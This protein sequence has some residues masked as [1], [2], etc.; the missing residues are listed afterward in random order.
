[1][2]AFA[3]DAESAA[4]SI[5]WPIPPQVWASGSF[6]LMIQAALGIEFDP[7]ARAI[8]F[9]N[10]RLLASINQVVLRHLGMSG[11]MVDIELRGSGSHVS[12]RVLSNTGSMIVS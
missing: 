6:F 9:H 2:P 10:P 3:Y 11:A 4:R 8:R 1:M 5:R 12:L 7:A